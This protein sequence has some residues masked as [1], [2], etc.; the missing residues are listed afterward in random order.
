MHNIQVLPFTSPHTIPSF[1]RSIR[2]QAARPVYACTATKYYPVGT[3]FAP[4][5]LTRRSVGRSSQ[6]TFIN[7]GMAAGNSTGSPGPGTNVSASVMSQSDC[8]QQMLPV[9]SQVACGCVPANSAPVPTAVYFNTNPVDNSQ[10][11]PANTA[12]NSKVRRQYGG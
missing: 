3:A 10:V 5:S 1:F 12:P 9:Y 11:A 4:C 7:S 2:L 6:M 8:S